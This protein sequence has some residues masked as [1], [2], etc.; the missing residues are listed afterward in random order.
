MISML[1]YANTLPF[2]STSSDF[3]PQMLYS[4]A[5]AEPGV[6]GPTAKELAGL[7]LEVAVQNV[8]KH[9]EQFKIYW[10]GA[11]FITRA[12]TY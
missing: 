12:L 6:R 5:E 4:V 7:C 1:W 10:P 9:I 2:N 3:Y 11:L 8:D